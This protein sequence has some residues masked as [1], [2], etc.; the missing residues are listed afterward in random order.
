MLTYLIATLCVVIIMTLSGLALNLQWGFGGLVN[1]GLFGFYMIGAYVCGLLATDGIPP[2]AAM[3]VAIFTTAIVS[4]F[5]SLISIRL[6]EDYL[7]I[8]TLGF[9]ECIR[10]FISYEDWLTKGTL[11]VSGIP[12]PLTGLFG[13]QWNDL[14]FVVFAAVTLVI[15]YVLLTLITMSPFGRLLRASRDDPQIVASLGRSVLTVRLRCFALGGAILGLAGSLHAFYY[16]Y[17]DPTQFSTIITAYAFMAVVVGGR[18]SNLGVLV[19]AAVLVFLLE[20]SRFIVDLV[21]WLSGETLASLRLIGVGAILVLLLI[22][23]PKGFGREKPT[24]L[25]SS[26]PHIKV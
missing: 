14:T 11:G 3:V 20:G 17:I 24:V 7:A 10:Q 1:F 6:S 13:S 21:P 2:F 22:L 25:R 26:T 4:G 12:R 15:V 5:V 23:K 19:A 8:V 18:G 9:A 16:T